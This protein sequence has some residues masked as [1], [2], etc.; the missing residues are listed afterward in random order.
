MRDESYLEVV[1][2]RSQF[3]G[4]RIV[5]F[6]KIQN[7]RTGW[8]CCGIHPESREVPAG[9]SG[10]D[11]VAVILSSRTKGT[12]NG[13]RFVYAE[14]CWPSWQRLVYVGAAHLVSQPRT[15]DVSE[16]SILLFIILRMDVVARVN[17]RQYED[18]GY[19]GATFYAADFHAEHFYAE[20]SMPNVEG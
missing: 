13:L 16:F 11:L 18:S 9:S 12:K 3:P 15:G 10:N 7:R 2:D 4:L 5:R 19:A 6:L 17:R 14:K 1:R 20:H 8:S